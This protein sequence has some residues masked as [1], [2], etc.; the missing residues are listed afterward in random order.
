MRVLTSSQKNNV[1]KFPNYMWILTCWR[2]SFNLLKIKLW[3]NPKLEKF[4]LGWWQCVRRGW[5]IPS[6]WGA[7]RVLVH[8][9]RRGSK[10]Y[11]SIRD[12]FLSLVQNVVLASLKSF[13]HFWTIRLI[14]LAYILYRIEATAFR[15]S[16][17]LGFS[18]PSWCTPSPIR[19]SR[20]VHCILCL[21]TTGIHDPS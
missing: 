15:H 17:E 19:S 2:N 13:F 8:K 14:F 4:I 16:R 12:M 3:S 11:N 21:R 9:S 6:I 7:Q 5:W 10:S 20:G 1:R 18:P